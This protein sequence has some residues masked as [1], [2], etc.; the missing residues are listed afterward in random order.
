MSQAWEA[1]GDADLSGTMD[2]PTSAA[3][4]AIRKARLWRWISVAA[5]VA[6][7]GLAAFIWLHDPVSLEAL[8]QYRDVLTGYVERHPVATAT[9]Y[10]LVYVAAVGL[11]F[12]GATVLTAAGGLMFGGAMGTALALAAATSG[13]CLV[14]LIART[15]FGDALARRAGPRI[16][17][18]RAGFAAHGFNYLLSIRLVPLFPFWLVNLA[19]G[20]VGM[21]LAPYAAATALGILPGTA[22]FAWFGQGLGAAIDGSGTGGEPTLLGWNLALP[23]L[24]LAALALVPVLA[25]KWRSARK[26]LKPPAQDRPA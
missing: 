7:L 2:D 4:P 15:A 16:A 23:M 25:R 19:A 13:A 10:V 12:P 9:A 6:A 3:A 24:L 17:H 22:A 20:L 5:I 21:R 11:S 26:G 14:F 18:F 1:S 8:R